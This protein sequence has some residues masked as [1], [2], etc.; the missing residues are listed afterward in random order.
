MVLETWFSEFKISAHVP[1]PGVDA[2]QNPGPRWAHTF[3]ALHELGEAYVLGGIRSA[4]NLS[5]LDDSV[6]CLNLR[7]LRWEEL[8]P[9]PETEEGVCARRAF[10]T[11]TRLSDYELVVFGGWTGA[12]DRDNSVFVFNALKKSWTVPQ[13]RGRARPE[14][15]QG[16]SAAKINAADIAVYGGWSGESFCDSLWILD[17]CSWTWTRVETL[18]VSPQLADHSCYMSDWWLLFNGG[19]SAEGEN[20]MTHALDLVT[21][22]WT[23]QQE[24]ND[25]ALLDFAL[26]RIAEVGQSEIRVGQYL[27][28]LGGCDVSSGLY[29][30]RNYSNVLEARR[31]QRVSEGASPSATGATSSGHDLVSGSDIKFGPVLVDLISP[32]AYHACVQASKYCVLCYGGRDKNSCFGDLWVV[33]LPEKIVLEQKE[34]AGSDPLAFDFDAVSKARVHPSLLR[35]PAKEE[36]L[37]ERQVAR[38]QIADLMSDLRNSVADKDT[39]LKLERVNQRGKIEWLKEQIQSVEADLQMLHEYKESLDKVQWQETEAEEAVAEPQED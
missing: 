15:R 23:E 29:E 35:G 39:S 33:M 1:D 26:D 36:R 4:Q 24:G 12:K 37:I 10:H 20:A 34:A 28:R 2:G 13:V 5:A 9:Q 27:I 3:T 30:D 17:T 25:D 8:A 7:T 18:G 6:W 11:T 38:S 32:R 31:V 19:F 21:K 16:H 14:P 22:E